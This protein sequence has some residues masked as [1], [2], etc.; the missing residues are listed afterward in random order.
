[1]YSKSKLL[2]AA[3]I[4]LT[5]MIKERTELVCIIGKTQDDTLELFY[6]GEPTI[7]NLRAI[8]DKI[9][10]TILHHGEGG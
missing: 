1:M 6:M 9:T 3:E 7:E 10:Q 8:R 4:V 2:L 5:K